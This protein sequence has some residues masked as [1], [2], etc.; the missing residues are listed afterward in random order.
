MGGAQIKSFG[1]AVPAP[2]R[3]SELWTGFFDRH[4][5]GNPVAERMFRA[6]GVQTRHV[7][8]NHQL[9][10][11]SAWPTS[12]R[13]ERYMAEA[14]PLGKEAIGDALS[15]AGLLPDQLGMLVVSS[16]TGYASPGLN[17]LLARD[18]GMSPDL[19]SLLLGHMGCY[20]SLPA[21]GAVAD[22]V[23]VHRRPAL[24]LCLELTSLH[25]QPADLPAYALTPESVQQM[26]IHALFADAAAAVVVMPDDGSGGLEIVDVASVTDTTAADMMTWDIGEQGFRMGL[27]PDVPKVLGRHAAPA[28]RGLLEPH[29]LSVDDVNAWAIHPGGPAILE[30]VRD[31][32][33]LPD[34]ALLP[35]RE[36]LREYGN[37]SSPTVLLILERLA[38]AMSAGDHAVAL[39]FGP[40]LTLY[41][42]LL[43]KS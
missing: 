8:V 16:C 40:G 25:L 24:V 31:A 29:G 22:Y 28:V 41:A 11:N 3:Q 32:L 17:V 18:L 7:V 36:V 13:M 5:R 39:A 15:D 19:R 14:L 38:P 42:A 9:E 2:T 26:I 37:C 33:G 23:S 10:D 20:A 1:T 21:L 43:R 4:Y 27:S 30:S 34:E 35:S 6:V 12:R